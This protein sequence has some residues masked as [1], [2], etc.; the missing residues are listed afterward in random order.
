M[1]TRMAAATTRPWD[2]LIESIAPR[3]R[4]SSKRNVPAARRRV[5]ANRNGGSASTPVL[6]AIHV[7]PQIVAITANA[8]CLP[9]M[10]GEGISYNL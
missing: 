4:A 5:D 9:V 1:F 7:S 8:K 10:T 6:I 2:P 3:R